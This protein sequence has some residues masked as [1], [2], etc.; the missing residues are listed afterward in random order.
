MYFSEFNKKITYDTVWGG[1]LHVCGKGKVCKED[2]EV[3]PNPDKKWKDHSWFISL[4][5]GIT[6]VGGGFLEAFRRMTELAI[7]YSVK[8]I[9]TTPEL[10]T[11]LQKNKV[12]IRG[13]YDSFGERFAREHGLKFIHADIEVGWAHDEEHYTNTRM[14]IRFDDKGKP[15]AFYDDICPGISAGN[16][17]GGTYTQDIPE[18]FY[19]GETLESFA[20]WKKRFRN[21]ILKNK[22][23]AYFLKTANKRGK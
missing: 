15:Y 17:G 13:W 22:D 2:L 3:S 12:V 16:N 4:D 21:D 18:D 23:L 19:K 6:E 11:L 8:S 9:E 1:T 10:L 7:H 5:D 20:E 14:E